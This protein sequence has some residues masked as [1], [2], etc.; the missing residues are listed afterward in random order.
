V[1]PRDDRRAGVAPASTAVQFR[2]YS[3]CA[4]KLSRKGA[5]VGEGG[6]HFAVFGKLRGL[7]ECGSRF[8]ILAPLNIYPANMELRGEETR[9]L[10]KGLVLA[11]IYYRFLEAFRS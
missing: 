1:N 3:P 2:Q 6:K 9:F 10:L 8:V 5:R 4:I 11:L 7:F